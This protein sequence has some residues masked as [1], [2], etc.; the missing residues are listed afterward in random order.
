MGP[1]NQDSKLVGF[2]WRAGVSFD[3]FISLNNSV[4]SANIVIFLFCNYIWNITDAK[5]KQCRAQD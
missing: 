2:S 5:Q 4:S 1:G 3:D